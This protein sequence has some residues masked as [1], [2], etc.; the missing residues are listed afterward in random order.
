MPT[1]IM[2]DCI[3]WWVFLANWF[4]A[5]VL[6]SQAT[7]RPGHGQQRLYLWLNWIGFGLVFYPAGRT[8]TPRLWELPPLPAWSLVALTLAGFAFCW[9]ARIHIGVLWSASVTR[10]ADHRIVDTGPYAL[11]RHPIYTGLILS[12]FAFGVL[13][14]SVVNLVG[15]AVTSL[16]FWIKARLEESFLAA[17]LG[18]AAYADYRQR[19]PMLVPFA[20]RSPERD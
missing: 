1:P 14:G 10:K 7:A 2:A 13:N 6:A 19:T 20:Q 18:E 8:L 3:A 16:G 4:A 11:V 15:A 9:W 5:A 12:A 17:E